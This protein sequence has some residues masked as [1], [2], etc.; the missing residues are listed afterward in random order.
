[1]FHK[2]K[3]VIALKNCFLP[4][5]FVEGISKIYDVKPLFKKWDVFN[6]L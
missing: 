5:S 1:M 2:V 3:N 6:N 4:V